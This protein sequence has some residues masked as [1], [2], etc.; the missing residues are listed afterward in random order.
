MTVA[1]L[2]ER[3][4]RDDALGTAVL[5][6]LEDQLASTRGMLAVVLEQ[7]AAI[8]ARDVKSVVRQA[9]MLRGEMIRRELLE[10]RRAGLLAQCG[11]RLGLPAEAV[12]LSGLSGLMSPA[13]HELATQRSSELRGL[14]HELSREHQTN[15]ALMQVE[16]GF[17]DHLMGL[18][19]LDGSGGYDPR[20][21]N[22]GERSRPAGGGLRVLDLRA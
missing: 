14:L 1:S 4:V 11:A 15:R 21:G 9:G 2:P 20:G 19:E 3:Q 18:L 8:R 22:P 10:E 7:G 5:A 12:T 13:Q 17:L 16:L 6:H